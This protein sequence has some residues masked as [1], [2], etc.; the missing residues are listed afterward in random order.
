[1]IGK[2]VKF[3]KKQI[4]NLLE[5]GKYKTLNLKNERKIS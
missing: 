5:L 3:E 1:M 2:L 4:E